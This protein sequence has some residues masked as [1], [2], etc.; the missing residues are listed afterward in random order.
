AASRAV[1]QTARVCVASITGRLIKRRKPGQFALRPARP[2]SLL[3]APGSEA[4]ITFAS[5]LVFGERPAEDTT[6][7][8]HGNT[9]DAP[10]NFPS[11]VAAAAKALVSALL[12]FAKGS[13]AMATVFFLSVRFQVPP[14]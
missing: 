8:P 4:W 2:Q 1:A 9:T 11:R 10:R 12:S 13:G 14:T 6:S 5:G 7:H 3:A